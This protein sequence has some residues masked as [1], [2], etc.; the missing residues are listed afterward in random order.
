M[1]KEI[2]KILAEAHV[3]IEAKKTRV[4]NPYTYFEGNFIAYLLKEKIKVSKVRNSDHRLNVSYSYGSLKIQIETSVA[5]LMNTLIEIM[6]FNVNHVGGKWKIKTWGI[7]GSF[8]K[9]IN[10]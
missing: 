1:N 10:Y 5:Q 4:Y 2:K 8:I 6:V 3:K 9:T 7:C